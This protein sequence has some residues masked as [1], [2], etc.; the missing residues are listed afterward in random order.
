MMTPFV[1]QKFTQA[2]N[3]SI[4]LVGESHYLPK[5]STQ[6]L[7]LESWYKGD[8]LTLSDKEKGWISSSTIVTEA[9]AERFRNKAHSIW[10]NSIWE[11]NNYGPKYSDYVDATQHIG[12]CN[13]FQRPALEGASLQVTKLDVDHANDALSRTV[14]RLRPSAIIFVSRLA[15]KHLSC[16]FSVPLIVTPHPGSAWWNKKSPKYGGRRGRDLLGDYIQ[17]TT[18]SITEE[19][20]SGPRESLSS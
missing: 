1:G 11:I 17:G 7:N 3:P 20:E 9:T 14:E 2:G 13:F 10:R 19:S 8:Y 6:H 18:W 5:D 4:L 16:S 12:A 15:Y